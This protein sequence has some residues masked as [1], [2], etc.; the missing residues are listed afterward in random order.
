MTPSTYEDLF[1]YFFLFDDC[2]QF[3]VN[4]SI[5]NSE[6][7]DFI[8][9]LLPDLPIC[10]N[11]KQK[12]YGK[13]VKYFFVIIA[14]LAKAYTSGKCLAIPRSSQ[15]F[16]AET[17]FSD[18][19]LSKE[20][21][22]LVLNFLEQNGFVRKHMGHYDR[23][24][25]HGQISRYW[26]T[27]VLYGHFQDLK[28]SDFFV[29]KAIAPVILHDIFGKNIPFKENPVS[30]FF[31]RKIF[32]INSLYKT[33]KFQY[34]SNIQSDKLKNPYFN[35]IL[36]SNISNIQYNQSSILGRNVDS[37][38]VMYPR[39]SAV[40]S[41][42]D[43]NCGGRLYSII[44]RGMG[45]Q[46]IKK[47]ERETITINNEKTVEL[48]FKALHISILYAI[49]GIQITEDPY[50]CF[51]EAMR[52][53]YKKLLLTLLN[54]PSV[55][56]TLQSIKETVREL[57]RKPIIS[58]KEMSFLTLIEKFNPDWK[59]MATEL[60]ERHYPIKR[61]FGSDCGIYLQRLDSEIMLNILSILTTEG[62]P[63]LPIHDSVIV[64]QSAQSRATE[65]MQ[66]VYRHYLK[67]DCI[68]EA[69]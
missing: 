42:G 26:A 40:F 19:R 24:T 64:P 37:K 65:V 11:A 25:R 61:Y 14:N 48:D 68:V 27:N 57:K 16:N 52:P 2:C 47:I 28:I 13:A 6:V 9:S 50:S 62:I 15:F 7:R 31:S 5:D 30:Q 63:G 23:N 20:T 32:Y 18:Q 54:A 60:I 67:F 58:A 21:F 66:S 3:Q 35:N 43:F 53:L 8:E 34:I 10:K 49:M 45:W 29:A 55:G 69:K 33:N 41:R 12:T 38:E 46:N 51:S 44:Q 17:T 36:L 59:V 1:E 56:S 22:L 39:I 4:L